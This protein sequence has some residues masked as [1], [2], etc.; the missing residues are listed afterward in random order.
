MK[1]TVSNFNSVR[2]MANFACWSQY[3]QLFTL[4]IAA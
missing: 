1:S 4:L 2:E 3:E